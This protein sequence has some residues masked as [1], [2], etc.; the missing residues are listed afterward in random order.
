MLDVVG[1]LASRD[2]FP[3]FVFFALNIH[4]MYMYTGQQ[5]WTSHLSLPWSIIY[6]INH[7]PTIG[8]TTAPIKSPPSISN[9]KLLGRNYIWWSFGLL[10]I[11]RIFTYHVKYCSYL[12]LQL[13]EFCVD[14]TPLRI[15]ACSISEE[16]QA[17]F[18]D[19]EHQSC[20][21]IAKVLIKKLYLPQK[22]SCFGH[23]IQV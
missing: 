22:F 5:V 1:S 3:T 11:L 4:T 2:C 6:E 21:Y 23:E 20:T 16:M 12:D 14:P 19:I 15:P 9:R 8:E 10:W 7:R 17:F 13:E 18:I